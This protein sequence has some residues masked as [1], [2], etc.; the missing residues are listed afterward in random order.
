MTAASK[1]RFLMFY[2]RLLSI[3]PVS[4]ATGVQPWND[5]TISERNDDATRSG[6]RC[7]SV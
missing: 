4:M 5:K 2:K 7:P 3:P 6:A 1:Q